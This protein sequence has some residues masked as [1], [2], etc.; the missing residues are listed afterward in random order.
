MH[1]GSASQSK[2]WIK[3]RDDVE[4]QMDIIEVVV[5]LGHLKVKV[6]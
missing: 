5:K 1:S 3:E 2:G 4:V 6:N